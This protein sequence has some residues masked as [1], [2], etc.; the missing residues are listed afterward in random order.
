MPSRK[1]ELHGRFVFYA[2]D[3][4]DAYD[5]LAQHFAALAKGLDTGIGLPESHVKLRPVLMSGS[6]AA[7]EAPTRPEIAP[8]PAPG[9]AIEKLKL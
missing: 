3:T 9:P 5:K 7:V 6:Y 8:A 2:D 1:Y 4:A